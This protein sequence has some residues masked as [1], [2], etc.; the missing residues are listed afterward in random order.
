MKRCLL[1]FAGVWMFSGC[2][3]EP[4]L[5]GSSE[6]ALTTSRNKIDD[7]L[8]EEKRAEFGD[9]YRRIMAAHTAGVSERAAA[10]DPKV[11]ETVTDELLK[12]L[13]GLTADQVIDK[14]NKLPEK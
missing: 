3:S 9:A 13:D 11:G 7:S 2:G 14:A 6:A 8:S 4:T 12:E 10:K 5:D 1:V